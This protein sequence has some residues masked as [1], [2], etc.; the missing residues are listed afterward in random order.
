M[1]KEEKYN[2]KLN[3][4]GDKVE[5]YINSDYNSFIN[6]ICNVFKISPER[7]KKIVLS[8]NDEDGD[9][10]LLS[11]MEDFSIFIEQVKQKVVQ[12]LIIEVNDNLEDSNLNNKNSMKQSNININFNSSFN[13]I[14]NS[15][16]NNS[17]NFD[18]RNN[19]YEDEKKLN[20]EIRN[21]NVPIENFVYNYKCTS[22]STYPI[23]LIMYYCD[24]CNKYLCEKC[25]KKEKNLCHKMVKIINKFQLDEIKRMENEINKIKIEGIYHYNECNYYDINSNY[26]N[27]NYNIN[28]DNNK[29]NRCRDNT[30]LETKDEY[31]GRLVKFLKNKYN[32]EGISDQ[33]LIEALHNSKGDIDKAFDYLLNN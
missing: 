29:Y 17:H 16:V 7:S 5:I 6:K 24:K 13:N 19:L 2:I 26:N 20:E 23:I 30:C 1:E 33:K 22:C 15:N 31:F 18:N 27:N 11:N 28:L 3:F 32:V 8:Y 9:N 4:Y 21:N 14:T 12:E 10:I 25:Y